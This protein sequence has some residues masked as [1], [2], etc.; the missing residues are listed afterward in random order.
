VDYVSQHTQALASVVEGLSAHLFFFL[1]QTTNGQGSTAP[2]AAKI[3]AL[4][5]EMAAFVDSLRQDHLLFDQRMNEQIT[6]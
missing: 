6:V 3:V 4:V 2:D 1:L 5:D